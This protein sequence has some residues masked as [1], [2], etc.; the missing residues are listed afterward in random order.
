MANT[1]NLSLVLHFNAFTGKLEGGYV[2]PTREVL[3]RR[4]AGLIVRTRGAYMNASD[5]AAYL[6]ANPE[7]RCEPAKA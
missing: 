6:A 3:E 5:V 7:I 2:V 1:E 4:G